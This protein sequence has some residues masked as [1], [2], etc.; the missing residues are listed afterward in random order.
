MLFLDADYE[1]H[2]LV[3]SFR[4]TIDSVEKLLDIDD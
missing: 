4:K 1:M 3:W 2:K